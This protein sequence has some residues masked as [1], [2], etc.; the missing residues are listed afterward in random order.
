MQRIHYGV[1]D[2]PYQMMIA[3]SVPIGTI[4]G[5]LGEILEEIREEEQRKLQRQETPMVT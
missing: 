1:Q 4:Q 2:T 5:I 3:C